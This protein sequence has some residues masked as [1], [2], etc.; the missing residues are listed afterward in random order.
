MKDAGSVGPFWN[1]S[2]IRS[3]DTS[4]KY[5]TWQPYPFNFSENIEP[6]S[7][8]VI[9]HLNMAVEVGEPSYYSSC[10]TDKS[11]PKF[12][13][14]RVFHGHDAVYVYANIIGMINI[15]S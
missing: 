6:D 14:Y 9:N 8:T 5:T 3:H 7:W 4:L 15:K 11:D 12:S 1:G 2:W 10:L 13:T